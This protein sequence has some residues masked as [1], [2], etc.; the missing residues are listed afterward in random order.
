[1][2]TNDEARQYFA[3]KKLTYDVLSI[4]TIDLLCSMIQTEIMKMR[5]TDVGCC[6][7]RMKAPVYSKKRL[8]DQCSNGKFI[9][10]E[11]RVEGTHFED[12]E[13][14]TFNRDGFIGFSGWAG[15]RNTKPFIDA[16]IKW[17]DFVAKERCP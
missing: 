15:S 11:L 5:K 17:C 4:F 16:F 6:L 10:F 14:I 9:W 3:D 8:K 2:L 12:R 13:A 7:L 1:M